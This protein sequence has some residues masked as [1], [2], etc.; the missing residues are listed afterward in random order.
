MYS[1]IMNSNSFTFE[2]ICYEILN[3]LLPNLNHSKSLNQID[4]SGIDLFQFDDSNFIT[5]GFQVKGFEVGIFGKSQIDQCC[6]SIAKFLKSD[7]V[8]EEYYLVVNR[9][10]LPAERNIFDGLFQEMISLGRSKKAKLL[11]INDFLTFL[12]DLLLKNLYRQI[13]NKSELLY[14]EYVN[15]WDQKFYYSN[16]PFKINKKDKKNPTKYILDLIRKKN[17]TT[18]D[19][20]IDKIEGKYFFV[21]SEFGFGKTSLLL[22]L[23]KESKES[24]VV[25]MYLPVSQFKSDAFS[26]TTKLCWD[27]LEIIT[28]QVYDYSNPY[29]KFKCRALQNIFDTDPSVLLMFDGLDEHNYLY[30][31]NNVKHFFG[32]TKDLKSVC[33]FSMRK[34]FWDERNG[35]ITAAIGKWRRFQDKIVLFEWNESDMLYYLDKYIQYKKLSDSELRNLNKFKKIIQD[36]KYKE[37]YGDIPSRPLFLEMLLSD[38]MA[39]S[40]EKINLYQLYFNYFINKYERDRT[41]VFESIQFDRPFTINED[42]WKIIEKIFNV[43]EFAAFKMII[44]QD[45]SEITLMSDSID[46]TTIESY[47][48]EIG[49]NFTVELLMH[50]VLVSVRE[51]KFENFKLKFAHKSFQE[52]FVGRILFEAIFNKSVRYED[53]LNYRYSESILKFLNGLIEVKHSGNFL[54]IKTLR[55]KSNDTIIKQINSQ[56]T[57]C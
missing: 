52:F 37:Y 41:G 26:S 5:K 21:I 19:N 3:D 49:I 39:G 14:R 25:P 38:I 22:N 45:Y 20:S 29:S 46:E 6:K 9:Y 32:S 2:Q 33:F 51:R 8:V 36:K 16:I 44:F 35:S 56:H 24:N 30:K 7:V 11:D 43:M 17:L 34:S 1:L 10:I 57:A 53:L 42:K 48:K 4:N 31:D 23:F 28:E 47:M 50:S 55:F 13:L 54:N 12:K 27:I 15:I 18:P 40:I